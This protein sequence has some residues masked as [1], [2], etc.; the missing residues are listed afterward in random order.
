MNKY[1][2]HITYFDA[3]AGSGEIKI[4]NEDDFKVIEGA[5]QKIVDISSPGSFD[6]YYS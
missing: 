2:F 4:G 5:T 1:A 6:I 3:F